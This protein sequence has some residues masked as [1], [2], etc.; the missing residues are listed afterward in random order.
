MKDVEDNTI[1]MLVVS[2]HLSVLK[3]GQCL[4]SAL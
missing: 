1:Y 3:N 4:V 2:V